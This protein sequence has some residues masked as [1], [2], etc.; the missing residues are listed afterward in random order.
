MAIRYP[1]ITGANTAENIQQIRAWLY[2]LTDT[3]NIEL[4]QDRDEKKEISKEEVTDQIVGMSRVV[5]DNVDWTVRVWKNGTVECY[6]KE[7]KTVTINA[8][9]TSTFCPI[10]KL[11]ITFKRKPM[12]FINA[13]PSQTGYGN[14]RIEYGG[15]TTTTDTPPFKLVN[16]GSASQ[17]SLQYEINYFVI[18]G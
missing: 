11:P 10:R 7:T 17:T 1:N 16:T 2:Q 3:L 13:Q 12:C 18:G 5:I 14:S 15:T 8:G 6:G 4:L 9:E